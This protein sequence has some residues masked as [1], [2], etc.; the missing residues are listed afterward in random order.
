MR[1]PKPLMRYICASTQTAKMYLQNVQ[2]WRCCYVGTG[3]CYT[4]RCGAPYSIVVSNLVSTSTQIKTVS[5]CCFSSMRLFVLRSV[6]QSVSKAVFY[7]RQ[8][9]AVGPSAYMPRQF[10]LSVRLSV[11]H[12]RVLYQNGCTYHRNSFTV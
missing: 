8:H 7:A 5:N 3:Q 6:R 11:R 4:H 9:I 10:R 1:S 2:S 12:T